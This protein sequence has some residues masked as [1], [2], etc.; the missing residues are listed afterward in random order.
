MLRLDS[1]PASARSFGSV[2]VLLSSNFFSPKTLF[3]EP[4]EVASDGAGVVEAGVEA[5]VE[6]DVEAGISE[7]R[8]IEIEKQANK[9]FAIWSPRLWLFSLEAPE[10]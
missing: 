1:D 7:A 9:V 10:D 5:D 2:S 6:A 8:R 4:V 3:W